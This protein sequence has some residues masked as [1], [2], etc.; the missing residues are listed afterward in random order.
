M[1]T[2]EDTPE[3]LAE[4]LIQNCLQTWMSRSYPISPSETSVMKA[5]CYDLN[6]PLNGQINRAPNSKNTIYISYNSGPPKD[7]KLLLERRKIRSAITSRCF[8]TVNDLLTM[9]VLQIQKAIGLA[10]QMWMRGS[11]Q[12]PLKM[13]E[14]ADY[15]AKHRL[16][17]DSLKIP[18][19]SRPPKVS[20][21]TDTVLESLIPMLI[22]QIGADGKTYVRDFL[23]RPQDGMVIFYGLLEMASIPYGLDMLEVLNHICKSSEAKSEEIDTRFTSEL[24]RDWH[25]KIGDLT[26]QQCKDNISME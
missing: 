20:K 21:R 5:A 18:P 3:Q 26:L 4:K 10:G 1:A 6:D 17:M 8:D 15:I 22:L 16:A 11:Y 7:P 13:Y 12:F 24:P 19:L 25:Y 23:L 2:D 14:K 9:Q